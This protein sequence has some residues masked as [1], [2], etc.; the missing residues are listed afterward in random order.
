M[1]TNC[2][3]YFFGQADLLQ[4]VDDPEPVEG[5]PGVGNEGLA[6]VIA[7]DGFPFEQQDAVAVLGQQRAVVDPPGPPPITIAS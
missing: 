6:D 1:E 4:P 5:E 3:L 2:T 7:G